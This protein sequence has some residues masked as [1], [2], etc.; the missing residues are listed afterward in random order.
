MLAL[1]GPSARQGRSR[2]VT[3]EKRIVSGTFAQQRIRFLFLIELFCRPPVAWYVAWNEVIT[4]WSA[5]SV[6]A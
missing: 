6:S 5:G 2:A 1:S 3:E 4:V